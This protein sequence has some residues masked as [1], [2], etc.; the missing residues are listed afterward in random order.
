MLNHHLSQKIKLVENHWFNYLI[1]SNTIY[2][3]CIPQVSHNDDMK[4]SIKPFFLK[5]KTMIDRRGGWHY[6]INLI[7]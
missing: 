3:I 1:K 6:H 4:V 7:R 2:H 5:K